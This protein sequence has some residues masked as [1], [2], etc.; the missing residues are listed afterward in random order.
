MI[1]SHGLSRFA[2][3]RRVFL[4]M[5]GSVLPWGLSAGLPGTR[6]HGVFP[7]LSPGN[8]GPLPVKA[9]SVV[10]FW[11]SGGLSHI[12]T[13][14]P[15]PNAPVEYRGPFKTISTKS[16]AIQT[17]EHLPRL[18]ALSDKWSVIRSLGHFQRGTGD[19]HAGYYYNLTG[20]HPDPT[21]KALL[22]NRKPYPDDWPYFGTVIDFERKNK[23]SVPGV[24][25]L[26]QK[27]G[28]PEYTR[29]GQF[30]GILGAIHDPLYLYGTR[31]KPLEFQAPSV[32]L[33][34]S[35]TPDRLG[36]RKSLVSAMDGLKRSLE[37]GQARSV[38]TGAG[39][40]SAMLDKAY[41]FLEPTAFAKAMRLDQEPNS[42]RERY[43]NSINGTSLL[44]ARRL[45]EAG[46]GV[47]S[48]F[49]MEEPELDKL[50]KS[51]G[52]WDTHGNNFNC[53]KDRLLPEFDRCFSAF[54]ADLS[55][56]GLLDSTLVLVTSEMG[57]QPKVGDPRSGGAGGAG[58]DHWTHCMSAVLA[59]GGIQGGRVVGASDKHGAYPG[60]RPIAPEDI[61]KTIYHA[62]GIQD[63][64]FHGKDD[65]PIGLLPY[66]EVI[67][68]L[69]A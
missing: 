36:E 23:S 48:V 50:C 21:F 37:S 5:S 40:S 56:R 60:D 52:G 2:V 13:F 41:R 61:V 30:A 42:L 9:K 45:V 15:K 6:A 66:G 10:L 38:E 64:Q 47:V 46:V 35:L 26:P 39:F 27:P 53:L 12:D 34:G 8:P 59:G 19:H 54:L 14:D 7:V 44:L 49:W 20:R 55:D 24:V 67:P 4:A 57:R 32:T 51:G 63:P 28:F 33:H 18:A 69:L 29:P 62:A 43:G 3:S 25:T 11:L 17:T 1:Q 22:N 58:R 68:E 31:E 65:R 16:P